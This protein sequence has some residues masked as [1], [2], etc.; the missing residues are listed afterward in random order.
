MDPTENEKKSKFK[1]ENN[2]FVASTEEINASELQDYIVN[3]VL[4]G[5]LPTGTVFYLLGGI[6]HGKYGDKVQLGP[7]DFT[8]LQGFYHKV[9]TN[10]IKLK[11]WNEME[12]EFVLVPITCTPTRLNMRTFEEEGYILSE[13]SKRE[14]A[15]F[16]KSLRKFKEPSLIVFASCFSYESSIKD[17][18]YANG[19]MAT[20]IQGRSY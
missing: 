12:Y 1:I 13:V 7:V 17:Y 11:K 9:Y 8:L 10:L 5:V 20:L 6:H 16:A 2:V 3:L 4:K 14:I 18:L 15:R 19:I